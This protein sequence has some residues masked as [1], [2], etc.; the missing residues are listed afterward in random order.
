[1]IDNYRHMKYDQFVRKGFVD[2]K[3]HMELGVAEQSLPGLSGWNRDHLRLR[4]RI[5][6]RYSDSLP[7]Q[8]GRLLAGN[9]K[10]VPM[11]NRNF[12]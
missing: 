8:T 4:V 12:D 9:L 3:C 11:V 10:A 2:L 5:K 7:S 6:W 1:M